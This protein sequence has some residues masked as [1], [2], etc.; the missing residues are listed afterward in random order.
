MWIG[1]LMGTGFIQ[2]GY[3]QEKIIWPYISHYPVFICEGEKLTGGIGLDIYKTLWANMPAYEHKFI[4]LP[5]KRTIEDMK[6]GEHYLFYGLY[7]TPEREAIL[8]FSIPCRISP[9]AMFVI[10]KDELKNFG[11]DAPVSLREILK[12]K[13]L[14]FLKFSSVSFGV[15]MDKIVKEFENEKHVYTEHRTDDMIVF[16][17]ELLLRKRVDY[18]ASLNGTVF[19]AK[20]LGILDQITLI[21]IKERM[22][23]EVGYI[24]AP[25]NE[26]GKLMIEKVNAILRKEIPSEK[27]FNFFKPLLPEDKLPELRKQ[28]E[29]HIL[30]PAKE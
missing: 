10:R 27:F 29:E 28:Y 19:K 15:E 25:K 1:V 16:S 2:S 21:P 5:I 9:P 17:L 20:E 24:T 14:R 4:I 23:Y 7:K 18:F 11:G 22:D 6:N 26:W 13:N 8:H 12:N 3:A 30:K